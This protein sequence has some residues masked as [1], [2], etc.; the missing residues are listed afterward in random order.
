MADFQRHNYLE[1]REAMLHHLAW[2][3][4][5][6]EEYAEKNGGK[7]SLPPDLA[8]RY[9]ASLARIVSI[10]QFS[11]SAEA[12][13]AE[14]ENWI[15]ELIRQNRSLSLAVREQERG[16]EKHFP[17]LVRG[18]EPESH[19]EHRRR[20]LITESQLSMPQLY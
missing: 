16:W 18:P 13:I 14:L 5:M 8:K 3:H 2:M 19:K 4:R 9:N 7:A 12:Y 17:R 1:S 6:N 10:T 15:E 11:D 20:V